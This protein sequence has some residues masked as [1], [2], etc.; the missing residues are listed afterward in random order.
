MHKTSGHLTKEDTPV[1]NIN[2]NHYS[3]RICEIKATMGHQHVS[4][5]AATIKD[6]K[7]ATQDSASGK[8]LAVL[9]KVK[10]IPSPI[11]WQVR[12]CVY[13]REVKTYVSTNYP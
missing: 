10:H 9:Y 7:H 6:R 12:S 8:D 5:K 1:A 11:T 3:S 2:K 13:P 4:I